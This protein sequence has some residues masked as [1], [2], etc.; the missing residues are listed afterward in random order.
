MT[1]VRDIMAALSQN[2]L[3]KQRLDRIL[4]RIEKYERVTCPMAIFI[5]VAWLLVLFFV[6]VGLGVC[7]L[8]A[9]SRRHC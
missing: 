9:F 8:L 1:L 2:N 5:G 3:L 6:G 7:L 4:T